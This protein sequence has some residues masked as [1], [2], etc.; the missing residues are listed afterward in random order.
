MQAT[1]GVVWRETY[2]KMLGKWRKRFVWV[3]LIY[4]IIIGVLVFSFMN[5]RASYQDF[6]KVESSLLKTYELKNSIYE[7]LKPE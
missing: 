7:I 4:L 6:V 3:N 5:Q 1:T 2:L